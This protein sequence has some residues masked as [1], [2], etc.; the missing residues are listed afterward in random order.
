MD[1]LKSALTAMSMAAGVA[2]V[3][4]IFVVSA[5]ALP[6]RNNAKVKS[7][8][9]VQYNREATTPKHSETGP[10]PGYYNFYDRW[11]ARKNAN[12]GAAQAREDSS[13]SL[14]ASAP[15]RGKVSEGSEPAARAPAQAREIMEP[16]TPYSQVVDNASPRQFFA[17]PEWRENDKRV[18]RYGKDYKFVRPDND[19]TPA[20]FRV[21]IPEDG[22][23]TVYARWP[24]A[25]GNNPETRYQISTSSGVKKVKVN[26][27][28]DGG[29]WMRL[30]AYKMDAGNR[31]SVRVGGRSE[32]EGRVVADAVMVVAGTQAAPETGDEDTTYGDR[33][34]VILGA[35]ADS[36]ATP[37]G[38][39]PVEAEVLERARSHLGTPYRH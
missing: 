18:T 35:S 19:V 38:A 3:I 26:Q 24:Q 30:G 11:T 13:D 8:S 28:K 34:S 21:R 4:A 31:F 20:W 29:V 15:P 5:G 12:R 16:P 2:V 37:V 17:A 33:E 7:P 9:S 10:G 22:F 39:S 6:G 36:G 32:A 14:S 27:S 23:Y 1:R 25:K